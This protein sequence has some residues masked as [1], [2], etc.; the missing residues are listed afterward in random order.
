M[1]PFIGIARLQL[2]A[3]K[4]GS[5]VSHLETAL[6]SSLSSCIDFQDWPDL[7]PSSPFQNNQP[8]N[9]SSSNYCRDIFMDDTQCNY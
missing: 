1:S 7:L 9:R 6:S 2:L 5:T 3:A 8:V 4:Q